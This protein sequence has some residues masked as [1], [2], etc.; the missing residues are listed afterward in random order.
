[1]AIIIHS[2]NIY[3][4][5]EDEKVLNNYIDS[6][7]VDETKVSIAKQNNAPIYE[8]TYT[9]GFSKKIGKT[10][11]YSQETGGGRIVA[12]V[13]IAPTYF[14]LA[15]NELKLPIV[16]E[17]K[18][19]DISVAPNIEFG[20]YYEVE[21]YNDFGITDSGEIIWVNPTVSTGF[22]RQ[23][24]ASDVLQI[25]V[26]ASDL[27]EVSLTQEDATNISTVKFVK[28]T[29]T[30]QDFTNQSKIQILSGIDKYK[31]SYVQNG[32]DYNF[33][34]GQNQRIVYKPTMI[35]IFVY[36][37]V[38][39]INFTN[40][41]YTVGD[42][43]A[44]K[45]FSLSL[46]ELNPNGFSVKCAKLIEQYSKGKEVVTLLCD[47]NDY[48]DETGKMAISPKPNGN[49]PMT[50]NLYDTVIP[51]VLDEFGE[52]AP[53]STYADGTVKRFMVLGIEPIYDGAVWQ[54]ITL[55]EI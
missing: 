31:F 25:K 7:K 52:E 37:S 33:I 14:E 28:D 24:F 41:S 53:I 43:N 46:G 17:D 44:K 40:N 48:F 4:I 38:L 32:N 12:A 27:T 1:M 55:Q 30:G 6:I 49:L 21:T 45:P 51:Y 50:F 29:L 35:D 5:I 39:S 34:A 2:K 26:V 16:Q 18:S 42:A 54:K 9:S 36:G 15:M 11:G 19:I 3:D 20:I 8:Q 22:T 23:P 13:S 47:I 10:D